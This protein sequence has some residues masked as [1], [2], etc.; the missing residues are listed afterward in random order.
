LLLPHQGNEQIA[1][2]TIAKRFQFKSG[3]RLLIFKSPIRAVIAVIFIA[4]IY[5]QIAESII[6]NCSGEKVLYTRLYLITKDT[7]L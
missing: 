6:R 1:T 5:Y 7:R 2:R 3:D 4:R